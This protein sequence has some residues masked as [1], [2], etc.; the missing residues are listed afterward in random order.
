MFQ[1]LQSYYLIIVIL[2]LSATAVGTEL[3]RFVSEDSIYFVFNSWGIT[4]FGSDQLV[5]ETKT[6]P[7]FIGLISL[8][9]FAFI[10]L[11]SY[12]NIHR[13]FR[14]GRIL[15]YLYFVSVV[16]VYFLPMFG[17]SFIDEPNLTR[18]MGMGYWIFIAG[19]PFSFLANT[20]IK[21]DKNLLDSLKRL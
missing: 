17:K 8:A 7:A 9:L 4:K 1:R 15:F 14:L 18:E 5:L 12:K 11:M 6:V 2:C 3:F 20:A 21:R 19:F 16:T 10:C 13:Q